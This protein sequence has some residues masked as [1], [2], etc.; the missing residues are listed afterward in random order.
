VFKP[1]LMSAYLGHIV[2]NGDPEDFYQ[3][4]GTLTINQGGIE[5]HGTWIANSEAHI[6]NGL[7]GH[8]SALPTHPP[9]QLMRMKIPFMA[10]FCSMAHLI[11]MR[12]E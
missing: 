2:W 1:V 6:S 7:P 12:A 11:T 4:N 9:E 5:I 8:P 10:G 3:L